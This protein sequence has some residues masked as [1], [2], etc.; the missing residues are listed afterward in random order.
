MS[1]SDGNDIDY[2]RDELMLAARRLP[3]GIAPKRD[4]WPGIASAIEEKARE[5]RSLA[6]PRG[7]PG[8][9]RI[10]AQ[11]AAVVLLVGGSSGVTW[12]AMKQDAQPVAAVPSAGT[13]TFQPV[14]GSFGSQYHLGPEF[15]DARNELAARLDEELARLSPAT[16][17]EVES[18][19]ETIR[20]AI[21]EINLA[22]AEEPG[23]ALLQRLLINAYRDEL[24]VM[25]RVD[26][27]ASSAMRRSD[28]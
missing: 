21:L 3:A 8:W 16:R 10:F 13:L 12:F 15:L 23:N 28:I 7:R 19:L 4:L 17:V 6:Q 20:A 26:S 24:A 27:I 5:E 9:N 2:E 25:S 18:N 11:A 22:L 14:A 1:K